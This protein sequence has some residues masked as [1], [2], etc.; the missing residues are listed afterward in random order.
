MDESYSGS[1]SGGAAPAAAAALARELL[2]RLAPGA[3]ASLLVDALL[4]ERARAPRDPERDAAGR[5]LARVRAQLALG[6]SARTLQH[7]M[8]NPLTALLAEAQM[9]EMEPLGEEHVASV[10]RVVELARRLAAMTRQL[11]APGSLR[12]G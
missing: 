8:N 5:E 2:A 1:G 12:V 10:G 4:A 9:L 6:A 7:A 11:D 3:D